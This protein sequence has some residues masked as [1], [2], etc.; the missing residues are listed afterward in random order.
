MTPAEFVEMCRELKE[1]GAT[2][3]H[4]GEMHARFGTVRPAGKA[5][6]A[7]PESFVSD[8]GI[9]QWRERVRRG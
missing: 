2:E 6:K 3:V 1:L 4:A 9:E 5:P 7:L 8:E